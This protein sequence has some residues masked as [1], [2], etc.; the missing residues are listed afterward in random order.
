MNRESSRSHAVF[1][2]TVESKKK[3][4]IYVHSYCRVSTCRFIK[5]F[6]IT[7]RVK[8]AGPPYFSYLSTSL[9]SCDPQL[10]YSALVSCTG[11]T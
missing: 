9:F 10:Y 4:N 5:V 8:K 6:Y 3:V 11:V 7:I 1:T 2:I